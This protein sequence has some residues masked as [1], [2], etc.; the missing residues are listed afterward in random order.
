MGQVEVTDH[1]EARDD[2]ACV[3]DEEKTCMYIF[4]GYVNG[5]KSND[6]WKYDLN[7]SRWDCLCPGDYKED[8]EKQDPKKY[9]A[10]RIGA[11]MVQI[12]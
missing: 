2:H 4:G 8:Q 6:L 5:D 3:F 10:P 7:A 9:P 1:C 11:R 12:D